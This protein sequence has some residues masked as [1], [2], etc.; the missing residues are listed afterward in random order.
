MRFDSEELPFHVCGMSDS[1][2]YPATR[3]R[4]LS[5]GQLQAFAGAFK[6]E[7]AKAVDEFN[8]DVVVSHHLYIV[9]AIAASI[10]RDRP[11]VGVC[12]STGLR[13]LARNGPERDFVIK[14]IGNL[15]MVLCL[16]DAQREEVERVFSLP[17]ERTM[18][19]GVGF[20][21]S[22]FHPGDPSERIPRHVLYAGK[23]CRAKGVES[24]LRACE[25]LKDDQSCDPFSLELAGGGEGEEF[26]DLVQRSCALPFSR[27]VGKLDQGSLAARYRQAQVYVL[28]S[29]FEGLP[30][31]VVEA[32]ASGCVVVCTDLPGIR[33][34]ICGR[35]PNAPVTWVKPPRMAGVGVPVEEDLP[36]FERRLAQAM[37]Q[38]L[39]VR[40]TCVDAS[41]ASWSS[42][43]DLVCEVLARLVQ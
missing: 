19:V 33:S 34:W 11:V 23:I 1:M 8:P 13:Q 43:S 41:A 39:L 6:R 40:P 42:V 18:A 4:D 21:S 20:D 15:D 31:T 25:L 5:D 28:P 17:P 2:P 24:L 12:H 22:V 35:V 32:L 3:Y 16:H 9:T 7:I 29:F 10:I 30:L 36:A 38:A 26:A 37:R 14:G 27:Y